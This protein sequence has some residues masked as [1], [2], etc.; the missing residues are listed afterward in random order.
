MGTSHLPVSRLYPANS[1]LSPASPLIERY[2]TCKDADEV[3]AMQEAIQ[4]EI[5]QEAQDR[6]DANHDA[7]PNDMLFENPN[8]AATAWR[9]LQRSKKQLREQDLD[10]TDEDED[11]DGV[12]TTESDEEIDQQEDGEDGSEDDEEE[13]DYEQAQINAGRIRKTDKLGNDYW[14]DA[15]D[16]IDG[17]EDEVSTVTTAVKHLDVNES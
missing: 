11:A 17:P 5:A 16:E 10:N 12:E 1:P 8:H 6:R 4:T 2:K 13:E 3:V 14:V 7:D 15:E 9:P